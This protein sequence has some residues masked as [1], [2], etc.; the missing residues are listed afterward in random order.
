MEDYERQLDTILS[1]TGETLLIGA[2]SVNHRQA[3]DKARGEYRKF[4]V[5]QLSPV[6]RAYLETINALND[7]VKK[8]DRNFRRGER[9]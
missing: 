3:M 6:E 7:K 5:R 2:G 1:S 9:K 8:K 4:Q